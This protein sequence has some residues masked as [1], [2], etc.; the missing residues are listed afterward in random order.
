MSCEFSDLLAEA[1]SACQFC[2]KLHVDL[3]CTQIDLAIDIRYLASLPSVCGC[4]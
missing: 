3:L 2:K 4:F 1:L